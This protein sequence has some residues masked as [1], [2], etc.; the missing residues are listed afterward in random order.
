MY[1]KISE[2]RDEV[3]SQVYSQGFSHLGLGF[4]IYT[5]DPDRDSRTIFNANSQFWS[6]LTAISINE[7]HHRIDESL[8]NP[9]DIQITSTI[10][11]SIYG[12]VKDDANL[13]KWLNDNIVEVMTKD[14]MQGQIVHNEANLEVGVSWADMTELDNNASLEE[15]QEILDDYRKKA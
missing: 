6:T 1:P 15:I 10:Y 11:D 3:I 5:D 8:A 12:I 14:F 13:I 2:F 4:K 7:M 9:D